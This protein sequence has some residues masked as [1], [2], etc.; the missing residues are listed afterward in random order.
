MWASFK[1]LFFYLLLLFIPVTSF[2]LELKDVDEGDG[3]Y[4]KKN[5]DYYLVTVVRVK[6]KKVKIRLK[7]A[8]VE[9]VTVNKLYTKEEKRLEEKRKG[10]FSNIIIG[11]WAWSTAEDDLFSL[12]GLVDI[13]GDV[14]FTKD[15]KFTY[16]GYIGVECIGEYEVENYDERFDIPP[17]IRIKW[18]KCNGDESDFDMKFYL[19]KKISVNKILLVPDKEP[20]RKRDIATLTRE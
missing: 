12:F 4:Y 19:Y 8:T 16:S 13:N 1:A 14:N 15:K 2:S 10:F 6:D 5:D 17:S 7:D 11:K 18:N 9:W 20:L 3:Y